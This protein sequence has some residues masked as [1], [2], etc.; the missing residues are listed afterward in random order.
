LTL[1][2]V[3]RLDVA[4]HNREGFC[5]GVKRLDD[6]LRK[7]ARKEYPELS[8][9]FVL[10]CSELPG[11]ILGYYSLSSSRLRSDDLDPKLLK[12]IGHY[13]SVPATLLG[14]LAVSESHQGKQ[15]LRVGETLLID[16]MYKSYLTSLSVASFGMI[17]DVLVGE[18]GDPSGFYAKYGFIK[19]TKTS[20]KM[21]LPMRTIEGVL[22]AAKL[23]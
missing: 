2:P 7:Q 12:K 3:T 18:R 15:T 21:Y 16:A 10:T 13:G 23:V 8:V 1:N 5:C 4:V 11:E 9:T 20:G 19:C 14:R 6:F 22:K 17:V